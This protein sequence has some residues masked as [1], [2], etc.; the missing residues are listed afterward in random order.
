MVASTGAE[1]ERK[2]VYDTNELDLMTLSKVYTCATVVTITAYNSHA[3]SVPSD[4]FTIICIDGVY[5][6]FYSSHLK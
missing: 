3:I 1:Y 2:T 5:Y 4:A 6:E